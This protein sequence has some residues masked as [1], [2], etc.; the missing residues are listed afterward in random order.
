LPDVPSGQTCGSL[1]VSRCQTPELSLEDVARGLVTYV[2]D[3]RVHVLRLADGADAV[4]ARATLARFM[5][6]G[7][8]Y[9]DGSRLHL[10]PFDRLPL[11]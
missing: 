1:N 7:L 11:R 10:V 8:V 6:S 2:L 5:D 3:E 9:A 4:V